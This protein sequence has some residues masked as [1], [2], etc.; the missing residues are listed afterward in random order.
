MYAPSERIL[1]ELRSDNVDLYVNYLLKALEAALK[2]GPYEAAH[3]FQR[4]VQLLHS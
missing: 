3:I 2:T 1:D 4:K